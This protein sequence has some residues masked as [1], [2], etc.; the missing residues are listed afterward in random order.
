MQEA[1]VGGLGVAA[2]ATVRR[3]CASRVPVNNVISFLYVG[4]VNTGRKTVRTSIMGSGSGMNI[5]L[6]EIWL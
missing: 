1:P 4:A 5:L 6:S 3:P 2:A